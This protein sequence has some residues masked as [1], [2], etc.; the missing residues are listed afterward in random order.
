MNTVKEMHNFKYYTGS[1]PEILNLYRKGNRPT[2]FGNKIWATALVVLDYL[3]NHCQ[4][5]LKNLKILEIGCGWGIIGNYLAKNYN[6]EV[7][8]SDIDEK[9]LPIVEMHAKLNQISIQVKQAAFED[10]SSEFLSNFD[11]IIGSEV[12]Y[13]SETGIELEHLIDRAFSSSVKNIIIADPGRPDFKN[14]YQSVEQKFVT[15]RKEL[16]GSVNGKSTNI[17]H[18]KNKLIH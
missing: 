1:H 2:M 11:L 8:C 4:V 14:L 18:V 15:Q 3:D 17:M 13:S 12:C 9:V 5:K 10:L 7:T 6:C 16:Q